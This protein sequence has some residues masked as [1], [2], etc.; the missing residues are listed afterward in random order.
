[1]ISSILYI[2]L[3]MKRYRG[4]IYRINRSGNL[5]ISRNIIDCA[6]GICSPSGSIYY[7]Q[8]KNKNINYPP[9]PQT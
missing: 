8:I 3:R 1:M 7:E 4:F 9:Y 2:I 5:I 6:L